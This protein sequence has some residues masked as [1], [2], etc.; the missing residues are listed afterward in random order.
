M[1]AE[2]IKTPS[3]ILLGI[4]WFLSLVSIFVDLPILKMLNGLIL[5]AYIFLVVLFIRRSLKILC[6]ILG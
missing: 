3:N 2:D 1:R 4:I 6:L 5:I